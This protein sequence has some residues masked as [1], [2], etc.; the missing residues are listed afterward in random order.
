M[1]WI[2]SWLAASHIAYAVYTSASGSFENTQRPALLYDEV[3]DDRVENAAGVELLI[4][5]MKKF[6]ILSD[7]AEW[8][9]C[10][11]LF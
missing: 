11:F 2:I 10:S 1:S 3:E 5:F 7:V 4:R 8:R 9:D 6:L